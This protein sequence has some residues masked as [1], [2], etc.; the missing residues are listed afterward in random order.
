MDYSSR[1]KASLGYQDLGTHK[2]KIADEQKVMMLKSLELNWGGFKY[3]SPGLRNW[4][5]LT[6]VNKNSET[7]TVG[8]ENK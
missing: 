6:L 7:P 4:I 2:L 8:K 5:K 1:N 3:F